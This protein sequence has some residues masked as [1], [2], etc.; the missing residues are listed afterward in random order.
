MYYMSR[1]RF[2]SPAWFYRVVPPQSSDEITAP[3]HAAGRNV[4]DGEMRSNV[5]DLSQSHLRY[6]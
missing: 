3:A 5:N 2:F 1:T 4:H 6:E